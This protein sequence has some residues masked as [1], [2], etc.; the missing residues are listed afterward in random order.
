[1]KRT[2]ALIMA[3][4]LGG[5]TAGVAF[6]QQPTVPSKSEIQ[7][8]DKLSQQRLMEHPHN[9][10]PPVPQSA[11]PPDHVTPLN[12]LWVCRSVRLLTPVYS[13]PSLSSDVLIRSD[14]YAA[15]TGGYVNGFQRVLVRRGVIGYVPKQYIHPFHDN[16]APAATCSVLG[17]KANGLPE[18]DIR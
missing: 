16:L 3:T 9:F 17:T 4:L 18:L 14:G 1:M 11:V 8:L 2:S 5:L 6:A 7:E 10:G 12:G 13:G 15:A